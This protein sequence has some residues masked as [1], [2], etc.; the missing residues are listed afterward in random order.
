MNGFNLL[1]VELPRSAGQ[2]GVV[3]SEA[4]GMTLGFMGAPRR[5]RR[6]AVTLVMAGRGWPRPCLCLRCWSTPRP[7][8]RVPPNFLRSQWWREVSIQRTLS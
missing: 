7:P 1:A 2:G 3:V 6:W 5:P 8:W 4:G